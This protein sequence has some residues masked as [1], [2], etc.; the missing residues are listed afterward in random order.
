M[1]WTLNTSRL[2]REGGQRIDQAEGAASAVA[3][4]PALLSSDYTVSYPK[5]HPPQ[6]LPELVLDDGGK[7]YIVLPDT[8]IHHEL[9]AVFG[10]NGELVNF[11]VKDNVIV[12]DR[13]LR[14]M[15]LKLRDVTVEVR[16]K[17]A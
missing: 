8:V 9:P 1:I 2:E 13:L 6:W 4:D 17:G 11:R 14:K 12:I 3:V 7:T 16:K 10:E 15:Q 5:D